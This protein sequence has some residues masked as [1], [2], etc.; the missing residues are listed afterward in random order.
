M[1]EKYSPDLNP[2]ELAGRAY[3]SAALASDRSHRYR[4][5]PQEDRNF[6]RRAGYART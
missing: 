3:D 1:C 6:F 2:I 5:Q 4:F